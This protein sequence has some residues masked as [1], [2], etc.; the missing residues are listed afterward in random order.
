M[1]TSQYVQFPAPCI[2]RAF[3][4][5][6]HHGCDCANS[7]LGALLTKEGYS[8]I[9]NPFQH[10]S[11]ACVYAEQLLV[12]T[13]NWHTVAGRVAAAWACTHPGFGTLFNLNEIELAHF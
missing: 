12:D 6:F 9:S 3:G 1:R 5:L 13:A 4:G 8:S 10:N 2:N 11:F 7:H